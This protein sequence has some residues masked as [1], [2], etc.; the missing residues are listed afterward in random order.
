VA[1]LLVWPSYGDNTI[2]A[3]RVEFWHLG[4]L[5]HVA[6]LGHPRTPEL[7]SGGLADS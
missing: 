1:H 6:Y 7:S 2:T 5:G 4:R 3:G